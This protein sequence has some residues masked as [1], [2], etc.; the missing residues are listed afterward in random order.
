M[1]F[2]VHYYY[3]LPIEFVKRLPQDFRIFNS[4]EFDGVGMKWAGPHRRKPLVHKDL[5]RFG[6]RPPN[7]PR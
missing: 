3:S 1:S 4:I 7:L 5:R 2:E 6:I